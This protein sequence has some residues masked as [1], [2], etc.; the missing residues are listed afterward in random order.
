MKIVIVTR[1]KLEAVPPIISLIEMLSD[2]GFEVQIIACGFADS[3]RKE[4]KGRKV[5]FKRIDYC[6]D[7]SFFKMK[8]AISSLKFRKKVLNILGRI[9]FDYLI[10]E[11]QGAFKILGTSIKRYKYMLYILE[12]Y[13]TYEKYIKK[14]IYDADA[15][16]MPQYDRAVL[17][18]TYFGLKDRPYVLPNKPY[19][20]LNDKKLK[21]LEIKYSDQLQIFKEKK[22]ILYQGII[23]KERDLTNFI[24]AVKSLGDDYRL[25]LLG[26][27]MG[28]LKDYLKVDPSIIHINF[29]PAPD[30]LVFTANAYIGILTY[31]AHMVNCA[32]CAPNKL[33]EYAK[34]AL[35]ML[36]NDIPGLKYTI[37]VN[38]MGEIVDET[39][40]ESIV[41]GIKKIEANYRNY[42]EK[43]HWFYNSVDCKMILRNIF[44]I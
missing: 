13:T 29:I 22:V 20:T 36:G 26:K 34:Y 7:N 42:A 25:V 8:K 38:G 10:I 2:L 44:K 33:F 23:H 39:S 9:S 24:R 32:Y 31:D 19:F 6:F 35:P 30:Y 1:E 37:E 14:I 11:G 43:A 41:N 21:K 27:D 12:M 18:Q 16:I 3:V 4:L 40:E 15:V 5:K 17:Y 28:V